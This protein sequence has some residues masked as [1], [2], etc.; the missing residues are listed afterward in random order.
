MRALVRSR[1]E[2][3]GEIL[4]LDEY[5]TLRLT[6]DLQMIV[7]ILSERA[8]HTHPI[9]VAREGHLAGLRPGRDRLWH[10]V[11]KP[12]GLQQVPSDQLSVGVAVGVRRDLNARDR[13]RHRLRQ[14]AIKSAQARDDDLLRASGGQGRAHGLTLRQTRALHTQ[15]WHFDVVLIRGVASAS[16][17]AELEDAQAAGGRELC[18]LVALPLASFQGLRHA[19]DGVGQSIEWP[20]GL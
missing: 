11:W 12:A 20:T 15:S 6:N 2:H 1:V 14:G 9:P 3:R 17:D 18:A 13:E 7:V 5:V 8:R 10:S 19:P 4:V 16:A